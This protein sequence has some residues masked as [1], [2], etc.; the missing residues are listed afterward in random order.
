MILRTLVCLGFLASGLASQPVDKTA[1]GAAA[2]H[3]SASNTD[4]KDIKLGED[5]AGCR[6]SALLPRVPGC[7]IIQCDSKE[8]GSLDIQVG[9]STDGAVIK[10]SMDG[11]SE[12]RY[13][14]CSP[15]L[16]LAYLVKASDSALSKAG[17]KIVFNGKDEDDQ[18]LV[19]GV[20]DTQW[21]QISTYM[22][23]E[24]S[25]Y[26]LSSMKVP[27]EQAASKARVDK[28]KN[29]N[30]EQSGNKLDAVLSQN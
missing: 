10:E 14:L 19:T 4:N 16:S 8:A 18:P 2:V 11:G 29:Q 30:G 21:I 26:I 25:A 3:R 15:K 17:Y 5:E 1:A 7:S 28:M 9:L 23:N 24:Y 27:A 6:D 22:Y 12:V 20:R 13:Y